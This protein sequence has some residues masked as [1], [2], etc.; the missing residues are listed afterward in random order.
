MYSAYMLNKE[1]ENIQPWHTPF[2][3][4]N[5]SVLLCLIITVASWPAYRFLRRHVKRSGIP[6]FLRIFLSFLWI[7][8]AKGFDVV[9]EAEADVFL[10]LSCFF[11]DPK[12]VGNLTSGSSTFSKSSLNIWMFLVHVLLKHHLENFE[13]YFAVM[14]DEYNYAVVWFFFYS[15]SWG[16]EWKLMFSNPVATAGSSKFAGIQKRS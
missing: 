16:L 6:I 13:Y 12:D 3:I 8:T 11:D 15:L 5:Q 4:W 2:P 1:G 7:H 14:W 9:N 10:E